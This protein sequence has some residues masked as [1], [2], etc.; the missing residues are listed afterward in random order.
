MS[1]LPQRPDDLDDE[2][3]EEESMKYI[4]N[5]LFGT[6]DFSSVVRVILKTTDKLKAEMCDRV[7]AWRTTKES[8]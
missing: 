7:I 4:V 1:D 3:E 8:P 5:G 2:D 6:E